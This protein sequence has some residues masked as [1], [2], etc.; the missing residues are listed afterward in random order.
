V[1]AFE[2]LGSGSKFN[3]HVTIGV[4]PKRHLDEMIARPFAEFSFS[5]AGAAVFK[6]GNLGTASQRLHTFVDSQ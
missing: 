3:P 5:P 2:T 1:A 4:A 6:L